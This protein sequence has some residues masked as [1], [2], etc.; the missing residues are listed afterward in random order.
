[1]NDYRVLAP[2][3]DHRSQRQPGGGQLQRAR[4]GDRHRGDGQAGRRTS[5]TRSPASPPT[6]RRRRS[7][8]STTPP[9]RTRSRRTPRQRH[10][11]DHLRHPRLLHLARWPR[12]TTRPR[13]GRV[14]RHD[15]PGN[16]RQRAH[17]GP[18]ERAADRLRLLRRLR[19][20][21]P[22]E[23]PGR[24]GAGHRTAARWS[25]PRW[26]G[27]GWTIF[28]NKGKP[29][30]QYE[31]FFSRLSAGTSSSSARRSASARS[32]ATTRRPGG[33]DH[34]SRT[35]PTRRSCSTPGTRSPGTPTTPSRDRP[36]RRPRR[37]RLLPAAAGR[38]LLAHLVSPSAPAAASARRAG[39]AGKA[40]AY[41]KHPAVTYFD[42]LGRTFRTVADN[43]PAGS[44]RPC[45]AWTSRATSARSPTLSADRHY[46]DYTL[47]GTVIHQASIE[48]GERWT[49]AERRRPADR[50]LG[51]R[52]FRPK[53]ATTPR[54]PGDRSS[55]RAQGRAPRLAEQRVYGERP[56]TP[57]PSTCAPR[58][59]ALRRGRHRDDH[60][61]RDFKGNVASARGSS[62]RT[63]PAVD[64]SQRPC[65][66]A[67]VHG[68][69]ALR[70]AQPASPVT[71]PGR[72][73]HQP[74][75]TSAACS[76]GERQP[77][78]QRPPRPASSP[79][80]A[81]TPRASG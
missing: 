3:A 6:S 5:A 42:P 54:A 7:T 8:P 73:R 26:V 45:R 11:A 72:Q 55:S 20:R 56:P 1:M 14:R 75:T 33:R 25:N 50:D 35:T 15:R 47:T 79:A 24:A 13:G 29:V 28:N 48:A 64:W 51:Q 57:R 16:A 60:G 2:G 38:R 52:G 36:G 61:T 53:A 76:P 41:A 74:A 31:P 17:R 81:T 40:A 46:H 69:T 27:T 58:L 66:D 77:P 62:S 43:G 21:D 37:R 19:P 18:A 12:R 67:G 23:G 44:T 32:S 70:R 65:P 63:P 71:T 34:P 4:L 49:L 30:R 78:R 39:A 68:S 10:D 80:S 9:T 59:P 22:A